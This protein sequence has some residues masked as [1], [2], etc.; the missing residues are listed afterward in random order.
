MELSL[1]FD[2]LEYDKDV[3]I[4]VGVMCERG[5]EAAAADLAER[6]HLPFLSE[7]SAD[8]LLVVTQTRLEL[9]ETASRAGPVYVDFSNRVR[10]GPREAVAR[11]VGVKGAFR[12]AVVDA[13]AGLGGDAFVLAAEGCRVRM[14]ERSGVVAALLEDGLQRALKNPDT[15]VAAARMTLVCG[16]ARDL[17]L[18]PGER[19]DAVYLDPMYP[20]TGKT[21]LS[22]KEMRFFR[23]LVGNDTDAGQLLEMALKVAERRVVVKRPVK[24]PFLGDLKPSA[25][26]PGKTTRFDLYL[27]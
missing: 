14:V 2:C 6:L 13:T 1:S 23:E 12:P 18:N 7:E 4:R 25:T 24:A 11:A 17:L 21:A 15:A 19:P 22:R 27:V 26:V 3:V 10:R 5:N 9:R 8:F 16:E 20:E